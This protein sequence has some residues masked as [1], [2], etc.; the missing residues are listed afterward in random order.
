MDTSLVSREAH[1]A[2]WVLDLYMQVRRHPEHGHSQLCN[3]EKD[4]RKI[5]NNYNGLNTGFTI[6]CIVLLCNNNKI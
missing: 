6:L 1:Q 2:A 3:R 4:K 5:S